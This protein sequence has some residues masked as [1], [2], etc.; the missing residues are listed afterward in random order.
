ME[1]ADFWSAV[2]RGTHIA[3]LA[4]LFGALVFNAVV[5]RAVPATAWADLVRI[6]LARVAKISLLL[7]LILG[8]A[9]F[10]ARTASIAGAANWQETLAALPTVAFDTRFGRLLLLRLVLLLTLV[11][12][13]LAAPGH[14]LR[15]NPRATSPNRPNRSGRR[16]SGFATSIP[17]WSRFGWHPFQE[18]R[19]F[20]PTAII[21]AGGAL[22]L[23]AA[24][25]HFGAVEGSTG[26]YLVLTESLHL[27]AAGAWLGSLV[28]LLVCLATMPPEATSRVLRRFFPF[29]VLA[30]LIIAGTSVVQGVYLIGSV[31][32]LV[33]TEFGLVA[34]T[35][36]LLF[37]ALLGCAAFNRFVFGAKA[38]THLRRSIAVEA[39]LAVMTMLA[40]GLLAHLTPGIHEQPVWPFAWRVNPAATGPRF[41]EAHRTSFFM[42]PTGFSADAIMR[43][44]RLYQAD[45]A[46]C[47]G[48]AGQGRGVAAAGLPVAPPDLTTEQMRSFGDGDLFWLAGHAVD[49][50][51]SD[52]WDLVD[53]L[54]ANATGQYVRTSGRGRPTVRIPRF[55]ALC[56][57]GEA[58]DRDDFRGKVVRILAPPEDR[59]SVVP[60]DANPNFITVSLSPMPA[61][62]ADAAT[63]VA[64]PEATQAL[65]IVLGTEPDTLIGGEFLVDGNGWLRARWRPGQ[66]GGWA[67]PEM[68]LTRVQALLR[69]PLP[70]DPSAAHV[71]HN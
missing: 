42:S 61:D 14:W 3:A 18:S 60:S 12:F 37:T 34:L 33:G 68:L 53:Y 66:R 71:H 5:L 57:N 32:A 13:C 26:W 41:I 67:T 43:G 69:S 24:S 6:R 31:P 10:A 45:C 20:W 58:L 55:D 19:G 38:G 27:A 15:A 56:P 9:W 44:E 70:L 1:Q 50:S 17:K 63:C 54:R 35:K 11:P 7:S 59:R 25:S 64:Q 30:V 65:A 4:S 51:F 23:Q 21:L 39:G 48:T 49:T 8:V 46:S 47:H 29:G 22:I 16:R 36:M 40:A 28:P 52:R 62:Q 2:L